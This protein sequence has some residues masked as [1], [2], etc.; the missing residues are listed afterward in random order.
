MRR[1]TPLTLVAAFVLTYSIYALWAGK[2]EFLF[3]GLLLFVLVFVI[4]VADQLFRFSLR[5]LGRIW[6]GE[7]V[8]L[9]FVI[10]ALWVLGLW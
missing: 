10:L 3:Q 2:I 9:I 6:L 7:I 8:F 1:I 5:K 4:S